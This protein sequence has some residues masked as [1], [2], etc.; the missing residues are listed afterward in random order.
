MA[1]EANIH[2]NSPLLG[3]LRWFGFCVAAAVAWSWFRS[4]PEFGLRFIVQGA[5]FSATLLYVELAVIR[6]I[7]WGVRRGLR[8]T[9]SDPG[10]AS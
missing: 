1:T 4:P 6:M 9:G 2:R 5:V 3:E 7:V 8:G 10:D